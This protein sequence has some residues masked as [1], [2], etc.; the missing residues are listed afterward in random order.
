[1]SINNIVSNIS[2]NSN[3][4]AVTAGSLSVK[5]DS[6]GGVMATSAG[7]QVDP[8]FISAA[9]GLIA[10]SD[11]L[12]MRVTPV[13]I[14]DNAAISNNTAP[15]VINFCVQSAG[16]TIPLSGGGN[17]YLVWGNSPSGPRASQQL[18]ASVFTS[19]ADGQFV[20]FVGGGSAGADGAALSGNGLYLTCD[21]A[22]FAT[23]DADFT[24]SITY[25]LVGVN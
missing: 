6:A 19:L 18:P 16:Q 5:T 24:Y 2:L 20:F 17:I 22:N 4:L 9:S 7:L 25:S 21:T 11:F 23:G 10:N 14:V 1:M 13:A 12:N 3:T 8:T 15:L